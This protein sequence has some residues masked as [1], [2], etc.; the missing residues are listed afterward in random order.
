MTFIVVMIASLAATGLATGLG[1]GSSPS[2]PPVDDDD[3]PVAAET[4][5]GATTYD[6]PE[7]TIDAT[8]P[9]KAIIET[10]KG[11]LEIE[12]NT[13]A[14]QAVNSFAFL[15]GAGFHNDRFFFYVDREFVAQAGDPTCDAVGESTCRG[16]GGPGYTLPLEE[17][18]AGH[19]QWAVVA[20]GTATGQEV[21]GSQFRILLA[22][23]SRLD[24]KETVFGKVVNEE[25]QQLLASLDDF[26]PC[27]V[28]QTE[29]CDPDPDMSSALVIKSI[30]VQPA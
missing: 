2:P 12:L 25:G 17:T 24:G 16:R 9:H 20:P 5:T 30:T 27:S 22:P 6:R 7:K 11:N 3:S 10:N 8:E 19:E 26:V 28:V 14:P 1:G 23:D 18:A 29:G 21:H 13:D 15:A 4:P